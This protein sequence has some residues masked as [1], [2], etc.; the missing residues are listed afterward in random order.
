MTNERTILLHCRCAGCRKMYQ[1]SI[2]VPDGDDVPWDGD[3][4]IE[5]AFVR[6]TKFQCPKCETVY[7]QIVAFKIIDTAPITERLPRHLVY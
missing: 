2:P 5:S 7:A 3:E 1:K 4:L 6:D